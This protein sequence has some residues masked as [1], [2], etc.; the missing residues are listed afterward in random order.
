MTITTLAFNCQQL[1][2]IVRS[3]DAHGANPFVLPFLDCLLCSNSNI[4]KISKYFK[5]FKITQ[6]GPEI[7]VGTDFL[8]DKSWEDTY[9]SLSVY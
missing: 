7:D 4:L 6:N 8:C 1:A 9:I 2:D 3:S 5:D